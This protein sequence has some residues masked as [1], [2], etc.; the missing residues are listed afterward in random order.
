MQERRTNI[1]FSSHAPI[2]YCPTEDLAPRDGC[3]SNL[4]ERGAA[5][6]VHESHRV[7]ERITVSFWPDH[8]SDPL[9]ATGVVRWSAAASAGTRW[10]GV[11]LEWFPFEETTRAR[12]HRALS[13]ATSTSRRFSQGPVLSGRATAQRLAWGIAL[14]VTLALAPLVWWL[15]G[16]QGENHALKSALEERQATMAQLE[17]T[18]TQLE[19]ELTLA[20]VQL[21]ATADDITQL[22]HRAQDLATEASRLGLEVKQMQQSYTKV[23]E[24]REALMVRVLALE[25]ERVQL[26]ERLGSLPALRQAIRDAIAVR[27]KAAR[28]QRRLRAVERSAADQGSVVGNRG[29]LLWQGSPPMTEGSSGGW[30]RVHAPQLSEPSTP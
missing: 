16:V 5:L 28:A 18:S 22:D 17:H 6:R 24:E 20:R 4:S 1:R 19:R 15:H 21:A 2:Q 8:A 29:Y 7:G 13:L 10:H 3:L 25:Q 9:T 27:R 12:L 30:I 26:T 14:L 11:G 23:R